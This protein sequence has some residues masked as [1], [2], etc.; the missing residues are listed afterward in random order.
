MKIAHL[1]LSCFYIDNGSYQENELVAQ[2]VKDGHDVIVI[3]STE[4]HDSN[5][6]LIYVEPTTYKGSDGAIVHR[7]EY[8]S[9]IPLSLARKLR[10]HRNVFNL[11][12]EFMPDSILFHGACGW[13]LIT[14]AKYKKK[15][16]NVKFY[17]DS[18]EDWNNSA[19]NFISRAILHK[20]YYKNILKYVFPYAEKILCVSKETMDFVEDVYG[21][22][23]SHLEFFP[24]GGHPLPD[25]I[26]SE[27]RNS[28]RN[29][30]NI[31][32][33]EIL[34]VQSGKQTKRKKLLESLE[35]F[36][37]V[38]DG[39]FVFIIVGLLADE[40]KT[41]A[42]KLINTDDRIKFLGWKTAD[43]LVDILCAADVYVQ[44]GTQS[45]TM[46]NSLCNRCAIMIDD[47][48]SHKI[49]FQ[50]NGWL[51]NSKQPMQS[52]FYEISENKIILEKMKKK[53]FS[54]AKKMLDYKIL[55]KRILANN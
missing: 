23:R 42:E 27:K 51:I 37:S 10:I 24:L 40:I 29:K 8:V 6:K 13:E 44:P 41:K 35:A 43:E 32:D 25:A 9:Y 4:N 17:I 53:S 5:G 46:Q 36:Q 49:Y 12:E 28:T 38:K 54:L 16:P 50:N 7:I 20:L 47:V 33:D 15:Y 1:A 11:L 21:I 3:A 19:R 26:Y 39:K 22:K 34:F 14:V 45:V 2:H 18:H 55:S 30:L 52:I 48:P 31:K